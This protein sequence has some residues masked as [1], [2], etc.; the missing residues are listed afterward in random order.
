M[1]IPKSPSSPVEGVKFDKGKARY[2]LI[3]P[4]ALDELAKLYGMGADKY[5]DRNWEKGMDWG[6]IFGAM[7][8]HSWAWLRGER[9]DPKD[10]QP[11]LASVAWCALTLLAY[12]M[13]EV[14]TDD[15][16]K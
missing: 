8:R 7:M 2:D 16:P 10:G 11:H 9:Y 3:P 5:G 14:G 12:E 15:R 4:D 13:R 6:R 1:I